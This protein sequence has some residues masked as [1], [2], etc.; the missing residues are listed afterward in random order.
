M[1][2]L[3]VIWM[4]DQLQK[5]IPLSVL[6][7]QAKARSL[8][9]MLKD[10]ASDPTYT[11][12]F[13]ASHGWFQRFKRCHN[14]HSVKVSG[15]A[16][17]AGNEGAVAFKKQVHRII[18]AEDLCNKELIELEEERSKGIK[19]VEEVKPTAPRKFTAKKLAEAFAAI[20][21][22][23]Q[24]LEGMDVNYERFATADRQI[25]D[26][27]ACYRE[28]YNEKKKQAVQSKLGIFLKNNTMLA[29][30]S[31]NVDVSMPSTTYSRC[32]SEEREIEDP[33]AIAS[34]S[35]SN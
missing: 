20:S 28:I 7:I 4:E 17:H 2:K 6:M 27:L 11:Q 12:M 1:E 10:R 31:T 21:S 30:P 25:Q 8:F 5:H 34:P 13:K 15:E 16:A 3:L 18:V 23:L 24:M 35:S 9:N 32:S 29:K 26:A 33:I 14:F 22:G 19:A